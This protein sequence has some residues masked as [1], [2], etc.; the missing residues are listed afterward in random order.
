L[1]LIWEI[2]DS[3]IQKIK[4]FYTNQKNKSFVKNRIE[5]NIGGNRPAFTESIFWK[6]MISCLLTTQQRSGPDSAVTKFIS[7]SP[8]PLTLSACKKTK[9]VSELVK[10]TIQQF[11]S[12]R[13]GE[14]IGQ[15]VFSNY[16]WLENGGWKIILLHIEDIIS[17]SSVHKER[18]AAEIIISNMKGFGPKQSRNLLQSLGIAKYEIPIDSRITKWL[19]NFGFPIKL[20]ATALSD[21]NYYN[22]VSDGFQKLCK[23]CNIY[24]CV[25]DAAIFA[26]YDK[27]WPKDK[28]VW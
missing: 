2:V 8:F 19:N 14:M 5:R 15:E 3:D 25:M 4:T 17:N 28:L 20:S 11:G 7:T 12:I 26:S 24:P 27:E 21:N 18:T 16:N 9:N 13:R 23:K 10:S 6:S 22:F 1:N